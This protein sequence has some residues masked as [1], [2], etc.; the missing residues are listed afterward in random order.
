M[1]DG[2]TSAPD[3]PAGASALDRFLRL[4]TDVRAG[5][6]L[7]AILLAV[8]VFVLLTTYYI[9]KPIRE[10]LIL[11]VP[12]G[13]EIKSY[14]AAGIAVLLL[15]AV[16][17]YA[18]LASSVARRRLLNTVSLFFAACLVL[19]YALARLEVPLLGAFFFMWVGIFNVMVIAQFWAFANDVYTRE[20]GERLFPIL[21]FGASLGAVLGSAITGALIG[22]VGLAQL[23]LVAAALLAASLVITNVVDAR[24]RRRMAGRAAGGS[25][26]EQPI[27]RSG[28][29]QLVFADR[30]LLL[31]AFLIL[32]LNWVNTTGEYILGDT[33]SRSA[34]EA[35]AEG[36]SGGLSEKEFIGKF[37]AGFF[38]GVNA[39]GLVAQLFLVS[40]IIKYVGV[41]VAIMLLPVIALS[42]YALLA[43]FPI[44]S[45]VRWA[46][47]AEN[48]TDY[49]LHNTV[50]HI[51]FLPTTR[52]AKYKAKQAIDTF[53]W[54]AGDVL[55]A[56]LVFVGT[57]WVLLGTRRFSLVNMI[58]AAAWLGLAVFIGAEYRRRSAAGAPGS[59]GPEQRQA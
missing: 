48:A 51:L 52:E 31:I 5:E 47:T 15:G 26:A 25:V 10:A 55:S 41:R 2:P 32:L 59:A 20:E 50:R 3:R 21:A 37:Y 53:F 6:G 38:T 28:A 1:S 18:R 19:F 54:R 44:L 30:Y 9:V 57:H 14:L 27:G 33:V 11:S 17:A 56:A 22:P 49:S 43:F 42:G 58:L 34:A 12:H 23:L 36:R 16:P 29:F 7:T 45:V 4:F 40:R 8:N 24:E 13:A 39:A 46:K 35:V